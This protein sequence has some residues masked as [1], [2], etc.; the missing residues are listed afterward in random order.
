MTRHQP[1][2]ESLNIPQIILDGYN[3]RYNNIT[4]R[5][6]SVALEQALL[7]GLSDE[8]HNALMNLLID[9]SFERLGASLY[10]GAC[11]KLGAALAQLN[12]S[13]LHVLAEQH[14]RNFNLES[15]ETVLIAGL[16]H[17]L[18]T[19]RYTADQAAS[20]ASTQHHGRGRVVCWW[21]AAIAMLAQAAHALLREAE[22]DYVE[23]KLT[24]ALRKVRN[25]LSEASGLAVQFANW[26]TELPNR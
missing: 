17:S 14:L 10:D 1:S 15:D 12:A 22:N 26:S 4:Y 3:K 11:R 9:A 21:L 23:E 6:F 7:D 18:E 2:P 13:D 5:A 24:R 16:L 25:G 19:L 20:T 8:R